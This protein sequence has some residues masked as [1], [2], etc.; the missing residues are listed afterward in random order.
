MPQIIER[1]ALIKRCATPALSKV[2]EAEAKPSRSIWFSESLIRLLCIR[3][4]RCCCCLC[5]CL[6]LCHDGSHYRMQMPAEYKRKHGGAAPAVRTV[7]TVTSIISAA[8]ARAFPAATGAEPAPRGNGP[9]GG[10]PEKDGFC[11]LS[12]AA[13]ALRMP[14]P[15]GTAPHADPAFARVRGAA[16]QPPSRAPACPGMPAGV[17]KPGAV[18]GQSGTGKTGLPDCMICLNGRPWTCGGGAGKLT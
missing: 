17:G 9:H 18:A 10:R 6:C 2:P 15:F 3:L 12:H 11:P 8:P 7:R 5:L 4:L 14:E 13:A 1:S 16:W